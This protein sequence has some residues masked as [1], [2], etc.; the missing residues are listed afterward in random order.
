M[1]LISDME[2]GVLVYVR[3]SFKNTDGTYEYDLFFSETPEFVWGPD[4]DVMNP[5]VCEDLTP[6]EST[7]SS[8]YHVKTTLPLKTAEEISCFSME[9]ATYKMLALAWID[10]ENLTEY[11]EHGR[12]ALHFGDSFESVG[13]KL[14][15]YGWDL[16]K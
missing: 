9:Y 15:M 7:Y 6:E 4:W 5:S 13:T 8:V 10:I 11:P 16:E 3:P 2:N 14:A 1:I 12:I